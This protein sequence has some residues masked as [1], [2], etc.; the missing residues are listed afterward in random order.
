MSTISNTPDAPVINPSISAEDIQGLLQIVDLATQR[1]A[2]KAAEL[3]QIGQ[4]FDKVSAFLMSIA[5]QQKPAT[6]PVP[7]VQT[8]TP[9]PMNIPPSQ[10][11]PLQYQGGPTPT[12][13]NKG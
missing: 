2:F 10:G 13:L 5:A 6:P 3:G 12:F 1:G 8:V 7:E 4:I 11:L 9:I